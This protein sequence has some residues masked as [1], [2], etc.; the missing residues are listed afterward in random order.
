MRVHPKEC[1]DVLPWIDATA[2]TAGVAKVLGP[3]PPDLGGKVGCLCDSKACADSLSGQHA[4]VVSPA[5]K[6]EQAHLPP[7]LTDGFRMLAFAGDW[8]GNTAW[9]V[10][11]I[12]EV[13]TANVPVLAWEHSVGRGQDPRSG[14]GKRPRL[15]PRR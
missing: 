8:H 14:N 10:A 4:V 2:S 15:D 5:V 6:S 7:A 12:R 9:A 13:G 1:A 3:P 11:R